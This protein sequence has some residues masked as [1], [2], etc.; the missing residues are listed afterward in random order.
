MSLK[1]QPSSKHKQNKKNNSNPPQTIYIQK[2]KYLF[3][4]TTKVRRAN[5]DPELLE[6]WEACNTDPLVSINNP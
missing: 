5:G 1:T 2:G 4:V 3:L 6:C